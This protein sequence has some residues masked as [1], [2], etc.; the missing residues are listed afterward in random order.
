MPRAGWILV[1]VAVGVVV[2]GLLAAALVV[3]AGSDEDATEGTLTLEAT[4]RLELPLAADE[5]TLMLAARSG[6]VLVGLAAKPDGP[7]QVAVV[8]AED[9]VP[10]SELTFT[11]DGRRVTPTPCGHACSEL[12]VQ[13]ARE[14][15]VNAPETVRF[16][17]PATPP[18]SGAALFAEV[19][20]TME[21]LRTYRFHEQL[22]SGVGRGLSSTWEVQAPNRMRFRTADGFRS[23]L[24]GR[25]RWDYSGGRWERTP[26][27]GLRVPSYMWDGAGN[28][29]ILR[30]V[31]GKEVLSV[32]DHEP[33]PAWFRLTVDREHRVLDAEMLAPSHFMRQR[34]RDFNTQIR[35][36]PPT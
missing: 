1:L 20:R 10:A 28:A 23:V 31:G 15:V 18:P 25:A 8:E 5:G 3:A 22:T 36:T 33:L 12:D 30:S 16:Q 17:L 11:V 26:Y 32:F 35:I 14:V 7:I 19:T 34:F 21:G 2:V 4:R 24:I 6:R 9:A 13:A 27:P 29:R